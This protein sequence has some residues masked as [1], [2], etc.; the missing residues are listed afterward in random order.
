MPFVAPPSQLIIKV[1]QKKC[2]LDFLHKPDIP[3]TN[4]RNGEKSGT[5]KIGDCRGA[6][7]AIFPSQGLD[8]RVLAPWPWHVDPAVKRG[9][10]YTEP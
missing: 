3:K 7:S 2:G 1:E 9:S 4:I 5:G 6:H 10:G 8:T